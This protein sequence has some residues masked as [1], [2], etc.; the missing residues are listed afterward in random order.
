MF[1]KNTMVL[2]S[3]K[4]MIQKQDI[5]SFRNLVYGKDTLESKEDFIETLEIAIKTSQQEPVLD[6]IKE[7]IK[8]NT[9]FINETTE[10]EGIDFET[11]EKIID[12][13]KAEIDKE[14]CLDELGLD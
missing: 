2:S 8:D 6:K 13:Y 4:N 9:Y 10:K 7:E 3:L 5:K 11:V 14:E 1:N 12:K